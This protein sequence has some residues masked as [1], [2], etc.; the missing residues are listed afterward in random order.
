MKLNVLQKFTLLSVLVT[1]VL[2]VGLGLLVTRLLT[3]NLLNREA[4]ITA[5]AIRTVTNI[6]LPHR[7]F[8]SAIFN[9]SSAPFEY[10][11]SH[12]VEIPGVFRIKFYSVDGTVVW[13]NEAKLIGSR[14]ENNEELDE[15]LQGQIEV[16]MG[17]EKEEH[18]YERD[19]HS[20]KET[21]EIYVPL[22]SRIDGE[23]YGVVEIYKRP[24][25]F[26]ANK[27]RL[28]RWIWLASC[29]G[30]SLLFLSLFHL[31]RS[32]LGEQRRLAEVE[33]KYDAIEG[34]L[35]I[36]RSIQ[37]GLLPTSLPEAPGLS[38]AAH[39]HSWRE[40]GGD[41]YDVFEDKEGNL[42]LVVADNEG[43]GVP[44]ALL[45]EQTRSLMRAH[46]HSSS[47]V[48]AVVEALNVEFAHQSRSIHMVTL[49][50]AKVDV[51]SRR[52]SYCSAGHCPGLFVRDGK[53][54]ALGC[55][56]MP[57]GA[58]A[59]EEYEQSEIDLQS[60]DVVVVYTDG[61]TEAF[62]PAG[63]LFGMGR[64]RDAMV[65]ATPAE[66]AQEVVDALNAA[67]T[68]FR[69]DRAESDDM[70]MVCLTAT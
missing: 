18:E 52:L 43:K 36:A 48:R 67:V 53:P 5:E 24:G 28:L 66:T 37:Q 60:G 44:G 7:V 29:G 35:S 57:L 25:A 70:T 9:K 6:D 55:G 45:M 32:A 47:D 56:G 15:A 12:F 63:E 20:E 31:F 27:R 68:T 61:F 22:I 41:Y 51:R 30:G 40:V 21:T 59:A 69:G 17:L 13:S 2:V 19:I 64:L 58:D 42:V 39:H 62:N 16:E 38:V 34:E 4:T 10:V 11:W 33:R 8:N 46:I 23:V 50:L 26:M 54:T 3:A 1:V 65:A 49:F 14:Y